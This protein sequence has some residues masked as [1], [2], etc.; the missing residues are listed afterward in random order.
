MP[1]R[2]TLLGT[3]AQK[4]A[5]AEREA[6]DT[7]DPGEVRE[8]LEEVQHVG[9]APAD[10]RH[11]LAIDLKAPA[12]QPHLSLAVDDLDKRTDGEIE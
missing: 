6:D 8:L 5:Q 11:L 9:Q 1:L 4:A 2:A 3:A 12:R 7:E 10:P